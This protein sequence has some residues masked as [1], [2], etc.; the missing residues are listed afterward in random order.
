MQRFLLAAAALLI[1]PLTAVAELAVTFDDPDTTYSSNIVIDIISHVNNT[2]T[3]PDTISI[4][5][6]TG[7]GVNFSY[8]GGKTWLLYNSGN[9][10]VSQNISAMFSVENRLWV[11]TNHN[12]NISGVPTTIS[13]G[14]S[15]TDDNGQTWNLVDFGSTPYVTGGD[16]TIFDITGY[17]DWMFFSGF[18]GGFH[19]SRS[20]GAAWRRIFPTRRDSINYFQAHLGLDSLS[21]LNRHFSCAVDTSHFVSSTPYDD[22]LFVWA[23]TAGGLIQYVFADRH[24]KPFNDTINAIAFCES[25]TADSVGTVFLGGEKGLTIGRKIGAPYDSHFS[26]DPNGPLPS[27]K[28][29]ALH[30]FN[31]RLFVGTIDI[32][33]NQA[34]LAYSDDVGVTYSL[35][36]ALGDGQALS[37]ASIANRLY[38]AA[39]DSGL[40]VTADNGS[41]WQ[42]LIVNE[43][44]P[45][46][47][48]NIVNSVYSLGDT[49]LVGTDTGLA[50]I[51][52]NGLGQKVAVNEV[53]FAEDDSS[54]TRIIDVSVQNLTDSLG[55]DT[56]LI[57]WTIH[58]PLTAMG[59]P[60]VGRVPMSSILDPQTWQHQQV[61]A[62]T[63]DIG[64]LGDTAIMAGEE[65]ARYTTDSSNAVIE[66]L[67]QEFFDSL[68]IAT[69]A[70]DTL[71]A[72]A[73]DGDTIFI[74]STNGFAFSSDRGQS[75]KINR[76]NTDSLVADFLLKF[77]IRNSFVS[78]VDTEFVIGI[79][80]NWVPAL[81]LQYVNN[82]PAHVWIST[83]STGR[84]EDTQGPGISRGVVDSSGNRIWQ[85]FYEDNFAWN[86]A[87]KGEDT[88]FAAT[89]GGLIMNTSGLSFDWDTIQFVDASGEEQILPGVPVFGVA[90]V[91]SFLWVG[92]DDRTMRLNLRDMVVD[93]T[94]FVVDNS[95]AADEVYA[96]P[97]PYSHTEN[98]VLD[99]HFVVEQEADV[100]IEIYDF[101]MNLV[102]RVI[103]RQPFPQGIFPQVGSLRPVWDGTNGKGDKVAVGMYYFRVERS[104]GQVSW[105]KLA[106]MP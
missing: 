23:G 101:A 58:R 55:A 75:F 59:R 50:V 74:G 12:E 43:A 80:S 64:F 24:V 57:V 18:A 29:T 17:K 92:T 91:D 88:I 2:I 71:T 62:I 78:P 56:A 49:L 86:F 8:D 31:G 77:D 1:I 90:V 4:W 48:S 6:A 66:F 9:G 45:L 105:G 70:N 100:T 83:R 67:I 21:L 19:A 10:L 87:F 72:L 81:G 99:F 103:D 33:A 63:Y 65:G 5:F 38:V 11:A 40:L 97:L 46:S 85:L 61:D 51:Y 54:S 34:S 95:S 27:T 41:S 14:L 82:E 47:L 7:D 52:L 84:E 89:D 98:Y 26:D 30:Y 96:F 93:S 42:N 68:V 20:R 13:D 53:H 44:D 37:F 60:I 104:T 32:T 76:P 69:M 16:R 39:E 73:I 28:V 94:L 15:W 22:S 3:D 106:V 36:K 79:L 102:K 25:C 35:S